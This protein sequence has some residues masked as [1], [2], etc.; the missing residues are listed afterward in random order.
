MHASRICF[1]DID[2]CFVTVAAELRYPPS[3]HRGHSHMILADVYKTIKI[4]TFFEKSV[5]DS[6][7]LQMSKK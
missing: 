1:K 4:L 5:V 7:W 6:R 3:P 2:D